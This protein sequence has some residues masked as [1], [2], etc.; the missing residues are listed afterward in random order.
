MAGDWIK[1]EHAT[2][3]KPEIDQIASITGLDHDAVLGK[4]IRLW[5]W[6]D[7]QSVDGDA[8][9][10]SGAFIDRIVF[11]Q[12]FAKALQSSGW[13]L[14]RDGRLS[15]PNFS[16]HNGESAKKRSTNAMRVKEH[17][18]NEGVI[19]KVL[20]RGLKK[21]IKNRDNHTCVYCGREEGHYSK[22]NETSFDAKLTIDHVIPECRGGAT[23][24]SNLV[25]ACMK[26]N[27]MKGDKTPSECGLQWPTDVTGKKYGFITSALPEIEKEIEKSN[28]H[29]HASGF[30]DAWDRWRKYITSTVGRWNEI[31]GD[32]WL[33]ELGRRGPEKAKRDI[34]FS[35][36]KGAKSILDSDDDFSKR[37]SGSTRKA[38]GLEG[39]I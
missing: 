28:T 2:L 7:Q 6:A 29:T 34:E 11:H 37:G 10:V 20:P 27:Q 9:T 17:R 30:E 24:E 1:V 38:K 15:I 19:K 16:R 39:V 3:D 22:H 4:C 23:E 8:L 18:R 36:S 21:K 26:C 35:I 12:G 14:G 33:M 31:Q 13:L 25:V 32:T 5:V